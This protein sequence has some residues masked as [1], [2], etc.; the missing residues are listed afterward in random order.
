MTQG[1]L[2]VLNIFFL[3]VLYFFLWRVIKAIYVDI[4]ERPVPYSE[5]REVMEKRQKSDSGEAYLTVASSESVAA[6][7][8]Y[9][10]SDIVTI[11]R[12]T[13]NEIVLRDSHVSHQHTRIVKKRDAYVIMDLDSTNGTTVGKTKIKKQVQLKSGAKIKIGN[14]VFKFEM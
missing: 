7:R 3:L 10:L 9:K 4:Y 2:I 5:A 1:Y 13:E 8:T 12:S 11:G 14:T 6:G